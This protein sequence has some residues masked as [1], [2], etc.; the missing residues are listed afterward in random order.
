TERATDGSDYVE[1]GGGA[2]RIFGGLGQD[3]LIGGSSDLY[4]DLPTAVGNGRPDGVDTIFGGA[5]T[6]LRLNDPGDPSASGHGRD[7]DVIVADNGDVFRLVSGTAF[8]SFNYDTYGGTRIVP[9][10]VRLLD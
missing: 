6:R 8:L 3:D 4:V 9:R 10:A 5:G 1:G 2:D 7:A